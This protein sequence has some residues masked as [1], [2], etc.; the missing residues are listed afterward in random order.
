MKIKLAVV[1]KMR[2]GPEADLV[3]DYVS[4]FDRTGRALGLGPLSI[5]E[6]EAKKG[7]MNAEAGLL[8]RATGTSDPVCILD[9]RG[10]S[11]T[12]PEFAKMLATWRDQGRAEAAFVIG[13]ADGICPE[14]QASAHMSM[15]FGSMVWPHMMARVM[16]TEQLYRAASILSGAPYHRN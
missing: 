14:L 10:R 13:G 12:S 16:L 5:V 9:E 3:K 8:S 4:R 1:G 7:G 6:V 2:A 15:S 11:M